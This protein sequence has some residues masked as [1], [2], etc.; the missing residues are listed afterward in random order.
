MRG[1]TVHHVYAE[2]EQ[3]GA[4]C[5]EQPGA[6]DEQPAGSYDEQP[7]ISYDEQPIESYDE[8]PTELHEYP[9]VQPPWRVQR[10]GRVVAM[11]LL[12]AAIAFV[13]VFAIHAL[14]SPTKA[15]VPGY[16]GRAGSQPSPERMS[17]GVR[18]RALR[19]PLRRS[20]RRHPPAVA[21]R[22]EEHAVARFSTAA[23]AT[24]TATTTATAA[25][26]RAAGSEF[27]FER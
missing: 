16:A 22:D 2:D 24:T 21:L 27:T 13:V 4:P 23:A 26:A 8:R 12:G 18:H 17:A 5:D 11:A 25:P 20:T 10:Q 9:L 14:T 1:R 7:A 15:V 19:A 6:C 3:P